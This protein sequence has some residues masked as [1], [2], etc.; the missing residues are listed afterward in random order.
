MNAGS[1]RYSIVIP[2]HNEEAT[3]AE[4]GRRLTPVIDQLDGPAE[5]VLVDDGSRDQSYEIIR[6]LAAADS[7]FKALRLSRNFGHQIAITAGL[8]VASGD[9]VVVMDADLQHP[10]EVIHELVTQWREGY[11]VVY[12]VMAARDGE[13]WSKR[14]TAKLFYRFLRRMAKMEMPAAAGDFRLIDR[15]ALDAFKAMRETNRYVR[16]M[17]SWIGFRQIGVMYASPARFAGTS[18][19]TY[20]KMLKLATDA[21]L[22]FSQEPLRAVVKVGFVASGLAFLFGLVTI[23]TKVAGVFNVPGYV[24]IVLAITFMG[25]IQLVV[26]GV[27]GEYMARVFDE[28]KRR[29]LYFVV[30]TEGIAVAPTA[31]SGRLGAMP[32]DAPPFPQLSPT[33]STGSYVAEPADTPVPE[34]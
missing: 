8:D 26:L 19:Y 25:G 20:S 33:N 7:R 31:L 5:V 32:L 6:E 24:T 1:P 22:S 23:V 21:V 29:P 27:I 17:F 14:I 10:P 34:R 9:A 28:V 4:L 12:A 3:L 18:K 30:E 13:S 11:Q 2:I 16:G 15:Q